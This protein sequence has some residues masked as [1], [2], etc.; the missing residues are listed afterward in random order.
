MGRPAAHRR[1]HEAGGRPP[2]ELAS[3]DGRQKYGTGQG[4]Q[5]ASRTA[6]GYPRRS[7]GPAGPDQSRATRG[8]ARSAPRPLP[9]SRRRTSLPQRPAAEPARR[10]WR[11]RRQGPAGRGPQGG[12]TEG[13]GGV[14]ARSEGRGHARGRPRRTLPAHGRRREY[15]TPGQGGDRPSSAL[16]RQASRNEGRGVGHAPAPRSPGAMEG[17]QQWCG[18]WPRPPHPRDGATASPVTGAGG[19]S[20]RRTPQGQPT[21]QGG[22]RA[23][24]R[25]R[26]PRGPAEGGPRPANRPGGGRAAGGGVAHRRPSSGPHA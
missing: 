24:A 15:G 8:N 16:A 11:P 12:E 14:R 18:Q 5:G 25:R 22:P 2:D 10:R 13:G 3:H 17:S 19:R 23:Q 21:N 6:A 1:L 4:S 9:T 20:A 7:R 26:P